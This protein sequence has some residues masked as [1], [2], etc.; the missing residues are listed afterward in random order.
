VVGK[1]LGCLWTS[2][3][4]PKTGDAGTRSFLSHRFSVLS[5]RLA[6][7]MTAIMRAFLRLPGTA[8]SRWE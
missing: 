2:Y 6:M 4:G 7:W 3:L 8:E 5:S 1:L